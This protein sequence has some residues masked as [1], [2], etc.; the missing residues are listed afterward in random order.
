MAWF[1]EI[2][3]LI[4]DICVPIKCCI[5]FK[6]NSL[7]AKAETPIRGYWYIFNRTGTEMLASAGDEV[8]AGRPENPLASVR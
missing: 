1:Q 5:A 4:A 8:W 6:I 2:Q 3:I 7:Y